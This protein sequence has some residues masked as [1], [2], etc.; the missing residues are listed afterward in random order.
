MGTMSWYS[1]FRHTNIK[2]CGILTDGIA[3]ALVRKA[4]YSDIP[5]DFKYATFTFLFIVL[6]KSK[7][8]IFCFDFDDVITI[9]LFWMN[10]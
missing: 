2:N 4:T 3:Y 1:C 8:H 7:E 9:E 6:K 10:H 5:T